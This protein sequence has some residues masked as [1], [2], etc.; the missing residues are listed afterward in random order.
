MLVFGGISYTTKRL[1]APRSGACPALSKVVTYYYDENF[2][3]YCLGRDPTLGLGVTVYYRPSLR[4]SRPAL[5][6]LDPS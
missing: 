2:K 5:A 3:I 4:P 6:E 1:L